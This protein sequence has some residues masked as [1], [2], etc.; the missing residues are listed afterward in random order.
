MLSQEGFYVAHIGNH[1]DF[2]AEK[3][4][5]Y[6]RPDAEKVARNLGNR[7]FPHCQLEQSARLPK[8]MAVKVLLGKDLLQRDDVMANLS[9]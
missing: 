2:G 7:F 9:N 3:T 1:W 8:G 5:I 6:Y 4:V